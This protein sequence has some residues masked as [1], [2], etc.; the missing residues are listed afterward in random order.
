MIGFETDK[1]IDMCADF[2]QWGRM[3]EVGNAN[4]VESGGGVGLSQ[5]TTQETTQ[6]TTQQT[7]SSRVWKMGESR[8]RKH[9]K[10]TADGAFRLH[11][12]DR[13]RRKSRD[14]NRIGGKRFRRWVVCGKDPAT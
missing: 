9:G 1:G 13:N 7:V 8:D 11:S 5:W 4:E 2:T 12:R 10:R 3:D 6:Q 14:R